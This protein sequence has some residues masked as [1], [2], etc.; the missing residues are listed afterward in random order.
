MA[1]WPEKPDVQVSNNTWIEVFA[2]KDETICVQEYSRTSACDNDGG[3]YFV[4]GRL[5]REHSVPQARIGYQH[6][7]IHKCVWVAGSVEPKDTPDECR[8]H[9]GKILPTAKVGYVVVG[10]DVP[11]VGRSSQ[12]FMV[13]PPG[14]LQPHR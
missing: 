4:R 5:L 12:R 9:W 6:I 11:G 3:E 8:D 1:S 7:Y 14:G 13:P 10:Y 2:R